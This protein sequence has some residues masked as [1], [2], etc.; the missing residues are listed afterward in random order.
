MQPPE[1]DAKHDKRDGCA[2][3]E[4][5]VRHDEA[6]KADREQPASAKPVGEHARRIGS[7]RI[8]DI[9]HHHDSGTSAIGSPTFCERRIRNAS[10]KRARVRIVATPTTA[11]N[12]PDRRF[13]SAS[14]GRG[15][16]VS[17]VP[18]RFLD[19]EHHDSQ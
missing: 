19:S 5:E 6:Q 18:S 14:R 3:S 15:L 4:N 12:R 17:F 2:E 11:Q 7:D 13:V 1:H 16:A 10:E 9:H 8:Y